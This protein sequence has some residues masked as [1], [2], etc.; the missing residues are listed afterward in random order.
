MIGVRIIES[1]TYGGHRRELVA[2]AIAEL[3]HP[4]HEVRPQAER[5]HHPGSKESSD[6]AGWRPN[7]HHAPGNVKFRRQIAIFSTSSMCLSGT[8]V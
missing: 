3:R 5:P 6:V 4:P 2:R 1:D 8:V 7:S